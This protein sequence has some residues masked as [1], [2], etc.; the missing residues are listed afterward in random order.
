MQLEVD[1]IFVVILFASFF[2]C[3]WLEFV[4]DIIRILKN[5]RKISR[6]KGLKFTTKKGPYGMELKNI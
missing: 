1:F 5:G 4:F 2:A 3:L 6:L